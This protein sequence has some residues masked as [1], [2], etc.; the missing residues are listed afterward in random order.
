MAI[1]IRRE[2]VSNCHTIYAMIIIGQAEKRFQGSIA[3]VSLTF[4]Q[5]S[6]PINETGLTQ[7]TGSVEDV[8]VAPPAHR[9]NL[10]RQPALGMSLCNTLDRYPCE[11]SI[12][13]ASTDPNISR[14]PF[15]AQSSL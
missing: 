5:Y 6:A 15:V 8:V 1:I 9:I 2:R 13:S 14:C 11:W 4:K 10:V 3:G 12:S 7:S